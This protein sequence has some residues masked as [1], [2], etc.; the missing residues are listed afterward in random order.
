MLNGRR[1]RLLDIPGLKTH[2]FGLERR[3][4][5]GGSDSID[6]AARAHDDVINVAAIA[7]VP[8]VK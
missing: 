8:A 2:L 3:T 6:H 1:C 5:S 4:A 7:L